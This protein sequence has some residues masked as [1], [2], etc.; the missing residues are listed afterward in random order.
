MDFNIFIDEI[1]VIKLI[2]SDLFPSEIKIVV[3]FTKPIK[4]YPSYCIL[5]NVPVIFYFSLELHYIF[6]K[7]LLVDTAIELL[8][9][10]YKFKGY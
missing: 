4:L 2:L 10:W 7:S 8:P 1:L 3:G 6:H 5:F 9:H